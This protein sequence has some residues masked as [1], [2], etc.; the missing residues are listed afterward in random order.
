M[1]T[2]ESDR[3]LVVVYP[4]EEQA[5]AAAQR[6]VE[7]GVPAVGVRVGAETDEIVA[8]RAEMREELSEAWIVPAAGFA[9]TKEGMKGTLYLGAI[10]TLI[11]L[12][13]AVPL[14][15]IDYG[16]T[17]GVRLV[18]H[19]VIALFFGGL[20]GFI[21]G[22]ASNAKPP[23]E[24]MAAQRGT[25]VRVDQ[26]TPAVREALAALEPIRLDEVGHDDTPLAT[27][28]T[29]DVRE[30]TGVVEEMP[31]NLRGD[32]Y[33]PVDRPD[34]DADAGSARPHSLDEPGG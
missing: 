17:L 32:G 15:F 2:P 25:V 30:D 31:A 18:V 10:A 29:E 4:T 19:V 16:A 9:A 7:L 3:E 26:D 21:A 11:A 20:V 28:V 14:A 27:V 8:L 33:H 1:Y 23:N 22:G 34:R 6:V 5:R 13:V 12:V 24:L